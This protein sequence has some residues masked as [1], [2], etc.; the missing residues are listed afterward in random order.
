MDTLRSYLTTLTP[1]EQADYAVRA[2][3]SIGYLRKAMSKGQRFDGGL[4]RQLHVQSQGAV[5]LTELRPDIWPPATP[6][7]EVADAA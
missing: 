1:A 3:T 6:D 7:A 2:G 4:V 5:S